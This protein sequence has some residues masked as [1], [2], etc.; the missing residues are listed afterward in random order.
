M[1]INVFSPGGLGSCQQLTGIDFTEE[2][3]MDLERKA[4]YRSYYGGNMQNCKLATL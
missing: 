1:E 4:Q 3:I 2:V